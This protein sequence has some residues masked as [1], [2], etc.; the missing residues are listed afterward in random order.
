MGYYSPT[1]P[2]TNAAAPGIS[3]SFLNNV[4]SVFY[5]RSG[6]TEL[7]KYLFSGGGWANGA[8]SGYWIGFTSRSTPVSVAIDTSI[9]LA[10][11]AAPTTTQL[12][13]SGFGVTAVASGVSNTARF[14][15]AWTSNY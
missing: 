7:G 10:G 2:F 3:A 1:G 14:G 5:R 12:V 15:G 13:Q 6:D 4:E 9:V 8:S 11:Y